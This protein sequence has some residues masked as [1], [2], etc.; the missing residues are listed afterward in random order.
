M[1]RWHVRISII[2]KRAIK[3]LLCR[4]KQESLLIFSGGR[5]THHDIKSCIKCGKSKTVFS[6][7]Q[8][9]W[10]VYHGCEY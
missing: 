9:E 10:R 8:Q 3:Q 6:G 2:A 4:H 1:N 5:N 7:T